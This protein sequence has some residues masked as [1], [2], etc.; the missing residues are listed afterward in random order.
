[1]LEATFAW[2]LARPALASVIAGATTPEQVAANAAAANRVASDAEEVAVIDALFPRAVADGRS[3]APA[4][5]ATRPAG[6]QR[7]GLLDRT[8]AQWP[9]S[10]PITR[11]M[12]SGDG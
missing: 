7:G 8:G 3:D 10:G 4:S 6:V 2:F 5:R 12:T 11:A 9:T 1:M